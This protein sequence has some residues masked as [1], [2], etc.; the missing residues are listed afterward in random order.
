MHDYHALRSCQTITLAKTDIHFSCS[1][2]SV[3]GGGNA[4]ISVGCQPPTVQ[5]KKKQERKMG[6]KE[7]E[8][9]KQK[10]VADRFCEKGPK[11]VRCQVY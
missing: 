7:D 6:K 4:S 8:E 1:H 10:K 9:R 11:W 3:V 5:K 2:S